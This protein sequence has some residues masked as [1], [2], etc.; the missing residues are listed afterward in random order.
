MFGRPQLIATYRLD[1]QRHR[2]EVILWRGARL[3]VD[4]P[5]GEGR[6]GIVAEL[7][8]GDGNRQVHAVLHGDGAYL[9]RAANGESGL[10]CWLDETAGRAAA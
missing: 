5:E 7:D 3:L 6:V 10:C 1:A 9:E 8:A 2:I 4:R